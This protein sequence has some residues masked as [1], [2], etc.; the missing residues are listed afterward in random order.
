MDRPALFSVIQYQFPGTDLF[1]EP[2]IMLH[3]EHCGLILQD[4]LFYLHPREYIDV[5]KRLIP[6]VQI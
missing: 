3:E 2:D 5:V 4:Q 6:Y 1:P